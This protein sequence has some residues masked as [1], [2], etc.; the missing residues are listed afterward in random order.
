M[1]TIK[2]KLFFNLG[3]IWSEDFNVMNVVLDSSLY[4]DLFVAPRAINETSG[5]GRSKP[6][7]NR[8][9]EE[10][11]SF[12]MTLAFTKSF[13]DHDLDALIRWL[14]VDYYRPLYFEGNENR[15]YMAMFIGE[16]R[17]SHNGLNEGYI[18]VDV[19]C[20]S[21]DIYSQVTLTPTYTVTSAQKT[22][23]IESD[24]HF[25]IYPEIS[26]I[27]KGN[28]HVTIESLDDDGDIFEIRDL[29]NEEDIY[30]N[31]EKEIIETDIIGMYRYDKILGEFPRI[32]QG[33]MNRFRITGTCEIQFRYKEKYRF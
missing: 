32:I 13:T 19:R 20:D 17:I 18:S 3:G 1:P 31:C 33:Q 27:K 24:G 22:I 14:F 11:I 21:A 28:G 25:D 15:V 5:K 7:F 30:I 2:D 23:E 10:P 12:D 29:T 26:I 16:P 4:D 6:L 9:D 8:I